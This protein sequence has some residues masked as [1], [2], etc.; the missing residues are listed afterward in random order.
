[1]DRDHS[2]AWLYLQQRARGCAS[3]TCR[4]TDSD[5]CPV[6]S[7]FPDVSDEYLTESQPSSRQPPFSLAR[8]AMAASR[9]VR[10]LLNAGGTA[11]RSTKA[12]RGSQ[13][14]DRLKKRVVRVA[15]HDLEGKDVVRGGPGGIQW[16]RMAQEGLSSP[17]MEEARVIGPA[18]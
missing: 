4:E 11:R 8:L 6:P 12:S 13:R 1:M 5:I 7:H 18:H 2:L 17:L 10:A 15:P 9:A 16:A 3:P 14:M